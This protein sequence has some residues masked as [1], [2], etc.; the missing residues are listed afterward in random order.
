MAIAQAS[1]DKLKSAPVS[2]VVESL[3][4]KLKRVGREFVTQCIWHEDTN[5]SLTI[6]DDKGFCF[7]H[8]CRGGGDALAYTMQA[9]GLGFADAANL[10]ASILG[11]QLETDGISPEEMA[12][13]RKARE[14][15]LAKLQRE[16][17]LYRGNL[18]HEKAGR[19]RDIL[20][21]RG[22]TAAASKEFGLGFAATGYF[23]G[24]ITVPILNHRNELVGWTGR[25][26]KSKEEQPAK[27]KNS[28]DGELFHKKNLVFNEARAKDA[29]RMTGSLIFV[30]GHLD[31]VSLWQHGV[32]NVV[33][34]QGTGAPDPIILQRLAKAADNFVLCFD[35]D[36][37]GKKAIQQFISAAGSMAQK[38]EIQINVVQ[39]PKGKDPDE[40]CRDSGAMAFHNLVAGAMPWLDWVIDYWAADLDL[41]NSAHVTSVENELRKVIDGLRSNAVRAHYID[42]VARALSRDD[43]G[44]KDV[45]KTWGNRTIQVEEREWQPPSPIKTRITTERR[46]LR[47]FVHRP[48]HRAQLQPLLGKVTHPPLRWLVQRLEELNQHCATDL[49]PHSIMAVVAAAEPFFLQ[50]LRTIIQP[51]VHIDDTPGVLKHCADTLSKDT[52]PEPYESDSHQPPAC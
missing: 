39:M 26:T 11:I 43:K 21:A 35:G 51:N 1:I 8:V 18:R 38:G 25:A 19:I 4:G 28:A 3:G 9:K 24:R 7:C 13:R 41:D 16:Q 31:V 10:A 48:E 20:K 33:A 6:N 29:A 52:L 2:T 30:E 44:A 45:A 37:G 17:E 32:A 34:M 14:D 42:K 27:Y 50:Q 36:E 22:L 15:A 40:V 12:K 46:M 5:P 47:I 23:A 49:T